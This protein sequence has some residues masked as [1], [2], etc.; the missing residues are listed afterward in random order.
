MFK[1][2]LVAIFI[3]I[4]I[5]LA[6]NPVHR[7]IWILENVL[8]VTI[9]PVVLWLDKRYSFNNWTFFSLTFFVVLH[10]FGANQT[11]NAMAYFD[12]FS[13]W[14]G[15]SRNYYD[16]VVH[17][18]FGLM[19]FASFF[20]IFYHQGYSRK[21]SYLIAILFIAAIGSMYE[22]LEWLAMVFYCP[23][24]EQA[25]AVAITQGDVWDSQ[26]DMAY[27]IAGAVISMIAHHLWGARHEQDNV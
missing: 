20:E 15:A 6:I 19:V 5:V 1:K 2:I 10:L 23:D 11:Y 3:L 27:A 14:F 22:I 26:K 17:F 24:T 7:G 4:W 8:V 13:H 18:L 16:Q 21:L 9:F 12:W 25:C